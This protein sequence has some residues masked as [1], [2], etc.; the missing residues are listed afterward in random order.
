M[1]ITVAIINR[2]IGFINL[3]INPNPIIND[4]IFKDIEPIINMVM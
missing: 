2:I 4:T 3:F 1:S